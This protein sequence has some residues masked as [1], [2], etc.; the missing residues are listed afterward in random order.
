MKKAI[1]QIT[2]T[3]P[4]A[5]SSHPFEV[6]WD[7]MTSQYGWLQA[8][9]GISQDPAYHAEGDVYTHTR[10]VVEEL[11][12]LHEWQ[13][14]SAT[15]QS[16]LF[17]AAL[18]H[19]VAKPVCTRQEV[20]G[21]I[22]SRGHA[23]QGAIMAR[24]ILWNL[25]TPILIR[26]AIVSL[27][28]F[29]GLPLWFLEK[30]DPEKAV[31]AASLQIPLDW[32]ALLAEADVRGRICD[33]QQELLTRIQLFREFCQEHHCYTHPRSFPSAHARFR[34]FYGLQADPCYSPYLQPTFEVIMMAGLPGAGKDTWIHRHGRDLP[35]ISLD[36]IREQYHISPENAQG[37]VIQLAR[38]QA[39]EYL[40]Q[41]QSFIWNA[42]NITQHIRKPLIQL[43]ASYGASIRI[44]YLDTPPSVVLERNHQR[45]KP[46]PD[47]VIRKLVS[48]LEVPHLDEAHQVDWIS[49]GHMSRK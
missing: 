33:D 15:E 41:K 40:R 8:L 23:K 10:M 4:F 49:L 17:A 43:F 1:Q 46:V 38:E 12:K 6:D 30:A 9:K 7:A 26:E 14:R 39:K 5:P 35:V 11:M 24:Q 34:Y 19:D 37:K 42:T 25:S 44:I 32:V 48:R 18:L 3:F 29:H 16:I 45:K 13:K 36:H 22:S 20:D 21:R 28:R 31:F 27:I 47:H 2:W